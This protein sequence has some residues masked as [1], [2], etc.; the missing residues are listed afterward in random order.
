VQNRNAETAPSHIL[1]VNDDASLQAQL[2]SIVRKSGMLCETATGPDAVRK[3]V[4]SAAAVRFAA[5][6]IVDGTAGKPCIEYAAA[7]AQSDPYISSILILCEPDNRTLVRALRLGVCDAI[8][9]P[10]KTGEGLRVI[11]RAVTINRNKRQMY[12]TSLQARDITKIHRRLMIGAEHELKSFLPGLHKRLESAFF[13]AY[14]AGGDFGRCL[15]LDD[16]RMLMIV[17]DTSGHDI[18]SAFVSVYFMGLGRGL[19]MKSTSPG[20]IFDIFNRFLVRKWNAHPEPDDIIM[21]VGAC[22]V[23]LDFDKREIS[24][25]CNGVPSPVLFTDTLDFVELGGSAPPFGWFDEPPAAPQ[26]FPMPK[27]GCIVAYTD[28]LLDLSDG[29]MCRMALADALLGIEPGGSASNSVFENQSD[30]VYVQRFSW[31]DPAGDQSLLRPLCTHVFRRSDLDRID[32]F[33]AQWERTLRTLLPGLP[34]QRR[35]EIL[36]VCRE[37][38]INAVEHGPALRGDCQCRFIMACHGTKSLRIRIRGDAVC[39]TQD[40]TYPSSNKADSHIPFG[41]KII[42]GLSDSYA[43][44]VKNNSI[45]LDFDLASSIHRHAPDEDTNEL[46]MIL[47]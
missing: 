10:L 21:S 18:K 6:L 7:I 4:K 23:L 27:S 37:A 12:R 5:A 31:A 17:G 45:L 14:E 47:P 39:D 22:Y 43:H 32:E 38:L 26:T 20:E 9:L 42:H 35:R 19:V 33:Q 34:R 30:D 1:I 40:S 24:C 2:E 28:G 8:T 41:M 29:T 3:I 46:L 44:D 25:S 15:C 11:E 16:H 13:P 36:L